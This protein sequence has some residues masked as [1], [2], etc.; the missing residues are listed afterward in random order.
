MEDNSIKLNVLKNLFW[1]FMERGGSQIIQFIVQILLARLLLPEDF[2]L[3]A[4]LTIFINLS[5]TVIQSGFNMALVQRKN[6]DEVDYSSVF[7][8]S[9]GLSGIIYILLFLSAP[10]IGSFYKEPQLVSLLRVLS[11]LLFFGAFISIQTAIVSRR[12]EFKKL[13]LSSLGGLVISG[14]S[15]VVLAYNGFGVWALVYQQIINQVILLIILY[16]T[17]KW[18]PRLVFSIKR[19]KLLFSFGW[20]ILLSQL[21]Y[22]L[23]NDT[24]TLLIGKVFSSQLLGFYNRGSQLPELIVGNINGS[25]QSVMLPAF[26]R[27]QDNKLRLKTMMRRSIIM[28]SYIVFPLMSGLFVVA[29]PLV[30]VLLTDK[31]L[32]SVPFIRIFCVAFALIP[33]HTSNQQAI[34]ALG[35]SDISLKLNIIKRLVD[36]TV[37]GITVNMGIYAIAFGGIISGIIGSF[38]N[39]YPNKKILNYG[40]IEQMKD[41]MPSLLSSLIMGLIVYSIQFIEMCV[42]QTLIFQIIAG[43]LLYYLI[44]RIFRLESHEYL[45]QTLRE[46]ILSRKV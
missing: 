35:R 12:M 28:S 34:N 45:I 19:V 39:A 18:R 20:K 26:A 31:W 30:H 14:I 10:F 13:F 24:R 8:L 21:L 22:N 2:G 40:Y 11:I 46:Y 7:Y 38:I 23:Y 43:I 25:I 16:F 3:I 44:S 17:V 9:F 37:L 36:F 32:P 27:Q 29:E 41:I 42:W 33:I 1:K 5:N 15:G 6:V 4:I